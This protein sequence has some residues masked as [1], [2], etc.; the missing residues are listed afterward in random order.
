M[1]ISLFLFE[2]FSDWEVAYLTP[3]INKSAKHDLYT[4][5][6][7]GQPVRSAGGLRVSPDHGLSAISDDK[8]E[9]LVLPGGEAWEQN[10]LS[11]IAPLV[12][13]VSQR[14]IVAALCAATG[15]LARQGLL[16]DTKHT[17]NSREYL[18]SVAPAYAGR[19]HYQDLP[20][21]TDGRIITANGTAPVEFAKE[22]FNALS[23]FPRAE[24]EKWFS[25]FKHGV[26]VD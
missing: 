16:K 4:F 25:L 9:L 1:N 6:L 17:S 7:D 21:L 22:I 19:E 20:A 5:T 2:G 14:G 15:F 18:L 23:V 24:V 11:E 3:E 13:A 12:A 8:I 10:L 26:W